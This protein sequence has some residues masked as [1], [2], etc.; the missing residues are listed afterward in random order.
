M[1][2]IRIHNIIKEIKQKKLTDEKNR[3]VSIQ[4]FKFLF[5]AWAG[6]GC[7]FVTQIVTLVQ[8]KKEKTYS[9]AVSTQ[10][11]Y[12]NNKEQVVYNKLN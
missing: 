12:N 5:Y 1:C 4:S 3:V 11:S 8:K 2:I 6:C 9:Y 7:E 10:C